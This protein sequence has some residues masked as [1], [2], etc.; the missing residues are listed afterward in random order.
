M[1]TIELYTRLLDSSAATGLETNGR[2]TLFAGRRGSRY[3]GGLMVVGRAV[4]GWTN[5]L[6]P[7][8]LADHARVGSLIAKE[9][10]ASMPER[11]PMRWV[12][13]LWGNRDGYNAARSAFWRVIRH[14]AHDLRVTVAEDGAERPLWS[15]ALA[16]SNLYRLAPHGGG[17]PSAALA[18]S[19]RATCQEILEREVREWQPQR[20]LFLTGLGW[21]A[22]F[23]SML[24]GQLHRTPDALVQA[25]GVWNGVPVVVARHPQG[26]PQREMV[27]AIVEAFGRAAADRSH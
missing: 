19:Q 10:E 20:L 7:G 4:N 18:R 22:P 21:L 13:D 24:D 14:V 26:K 3:G 16:W 23:D 27:A 8:D 9:L 12:S 2:L 5:T 15:S 25:R 11:E 6:R 17:N 1:P